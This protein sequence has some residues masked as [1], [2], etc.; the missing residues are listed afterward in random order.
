MRPF[1]T[2]PSPPWGSSSA[3]RLVLSQWA[4]NPIAWSKVDIAAAIPIIVGRPTPLPTCFRRGAFL[5]RSYERARKTFLFGLA[6]VAAGI[7]V[8]RLLDV[9]GLDVLGLDVLG[10]GPRTLAP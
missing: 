6:R 8:A 3:S 1:A 4:A 10:L 5:P 7:A 9:L 2:V